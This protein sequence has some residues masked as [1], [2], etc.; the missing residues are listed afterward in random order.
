[1]NNPLY[2]DDYKETA[3]RLYGL[4]EEELILKLKRVDNK[5]VL[6]ELHRLYSMQSDE[7][8]MRLIQKR[9]DEL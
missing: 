3:L 9:I 4:L 5:K 8:M 1:M 6:E 2:L 7:V